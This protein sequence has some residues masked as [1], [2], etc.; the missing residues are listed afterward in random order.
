MPELEFDTESLPLST[1]VNPLAVLREIL[2]LMG[3][4]VEV[5]EQN[6]PERVL[7]NITGPE[8]PLLI[9][10]K[11]QTLDALQFL[12]SKIASRDSDDR[13]PVVVDSDGYRQRR[14]EALEQLAVRLGEKAILSGKVVAVNPMSAH[15]R[16]IIHLTLKENPGVTT[17]SE[18]EGTE[19]RVLIVP[20]P[21]MKR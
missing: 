13:L 11:G 14:I 8:A 15:D 7:L 17:R 2:R 18:G 1:R 9:G 19:R 5:S 21:G 6:E 3:F 10:K 4:N 16:R 20:E 12:L